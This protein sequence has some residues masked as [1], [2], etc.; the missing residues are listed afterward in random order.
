MVRAVSSTKPVADRR[1]ESSGAAEPRVADAGAGAA[2]AGPRCGRLPTS[3]GSGQAGRATGTGLS[4]CRAGGAGA[5]TRA[6][7]ASSS[8]GAGRWCLQ[9]SS[10]HLLQL[11]H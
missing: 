3:A 4:G 2:A 11:S 8:I 5:R 6:N 7:T 10:A 9:L 1:A